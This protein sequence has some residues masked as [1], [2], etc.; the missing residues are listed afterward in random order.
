[1]KILF[2][3]THS[4]GLLSDFFMDLA[5]KLTQDDHDVK[6]FS[7]KGAKSNFYV[8]DV[9]VIIQPK[10]NYLNNYFQIFNCIKNVSPDVVVSNFSY[11]NPS[12]I[13]GKLLGVKKN[14]AWVHSL[15]KHGDPGK[16]IIYIKRLFYKFAD[17]VIVNSHILEK[18]LQE[19]FK[20]KQD[21][22]NPIPFWSNIKHIEPTSISIERTTGKYFIGCPGRFTIIKNQ[23]VL[24]DALLCSNR[25]FQDEIEVLLYYYFLQQN[26]I[27]YHS[28]K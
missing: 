24:I 16:H 21:K 12:L 17:K 10:S 19:V 7:L 23:K 27:Q 3:F 22:I 4:K 14:I 2:L 18:E 9:E 11:A 25:N 15:K 13:A 8:N 28:V 1:M 20:V 5:H 6:I 26:K